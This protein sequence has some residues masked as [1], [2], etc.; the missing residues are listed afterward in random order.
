MNEEILRN[1]R[2]G[3]TRA[4]AFSL[5]S[6]KAPGPDGLNKIFYQ[7]HWKTVKEEII[8]RLIVVRLQKILDKIVS[9]IQSAF[10]G[11][12]LIHDNIIIVQEAFHRLEKKRRKDGA[13]EIAIKLDM[14]KAYDR[15][16]WDFLEE[17]FKAFGF[18]KKWVK[19]MMGCVKSANYK[20][21]INGNMSNKI[22]P[23]IGLRQGNPLSPYLFIM[24]AEV[25][26]ILMNE[27]QQKNLI[28][29]IKLAPT[30]PPITHLLFT[31]DCNIFAEVKEEEVYQIIQVLNKCT[32]AS[33]QR[34]NLEKS[35]ISF[36]SLIPIQTRVNIKEIL[37]MTAWENLEKY[38]GLPAR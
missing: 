31:D 1:I 11:G 5:G 27:A 29:G 20:I 17:V 22:K 14:N 38:L 2:D 33:G 36:G 18:N 16:E 32:K 6:L 30:V 24:A 8:S 9:P 12:R 7:K 34:I 4:A 19:L 23:Q 26:T 15:L 13:N 21:K 3:E 25:F 28:S 35:G 37:G 10:I